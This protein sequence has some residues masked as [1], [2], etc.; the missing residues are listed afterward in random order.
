MLE[1]ERDAHGQRTGHTLAHEVTLYECASADLQLVEDPGDYCDLCQARAQMREEIAATFSALRI[2][3]EPAGYANGDPKY[4][5]D[6]GRSYVAV[7]H[8][9]SLVRIVRQQNK[10]R[11]WALDVGGYPAKNAIT[12][13]E[14]A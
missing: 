10:R 4:R 12:V 8:A 5:D 9:G 7:I 3:A 2:K 1:G 14:R 11:P 13:W 6:R